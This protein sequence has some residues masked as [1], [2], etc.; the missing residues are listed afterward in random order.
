AYRRVVYEHPHLVRYLRTV[1]PEQELSRLALGSRPARRTQV[2]DLSSLRAIPWVFAWTQVR[3][4]LSAWLGTGAALEEALA[5]P[6]RR[7][8]LNQMQQERSEEHTSELQ[9]RFDL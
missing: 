5:N 3:L 1:T 7:A 4:I 6:E 2:D 8:I 9:S